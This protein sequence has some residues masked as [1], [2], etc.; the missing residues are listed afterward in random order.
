MTEILIEVCANK[1][2]LNNITTVINLSHTKLVDILIPI[3]LN[4]I[5]GPY[6]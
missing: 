2:H 4:L 3:C 1:Y 6:Y 5:K